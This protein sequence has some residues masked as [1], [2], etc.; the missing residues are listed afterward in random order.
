MIKSIFSLVIATEED[1][2]DVNDDC[3]IVIELA[4]A[5]R[6]CDLELNDPNKDSSTDVLLY[7]TLLGGA[8]Y[9]YWKID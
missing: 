8:D 4:P 1:V 2:Y 9:M 5:L 3:F 6:S 7:F